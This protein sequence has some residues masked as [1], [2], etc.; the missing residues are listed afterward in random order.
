MFLLEEVP[1]YSLDLVFFFT[2]SGPI[3]IHHHYSP[4]F[5]NILSV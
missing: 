1:L 3:R 5:G 4:P 2:D